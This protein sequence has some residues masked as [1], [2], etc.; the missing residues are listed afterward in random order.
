MG[1]H[2]R[3]LTRARMPHIPVLSP[4][5]SEA[6]DREAEAAGISRAVLMSAAGRAVAGVIAA[7]HSLAAE[8]GVLVAAGSGNNGGDGWVAARALHR[9]GVAVWVASL[10]S[11]RSP[12][13]ADAARLAL[14]DGVREVSPDGPWPTVG[15]V[16]DA[17]LGTGARG[18]PR[19]PVATLLER[20]ADLS[21]PII[22]VDGPTGL[23]LA[24]GVV[25]GAPAVTLSVTFGGVRRGHLLARDEAGDIVVAD[26]GHPASDPAW[27]ALMTDGA[28]AAQ[29]PR[30]RADFHKGDRGRIVIIGGAAG[31]AGAA[32][33]AARAA[34]ATG[35]GLVHVAAPA[36][37][38]ALLQAAEPDVQTLTHAFDGAPNGALTEL[39]DRAD[40]VVIGPGLGREPGRRDFVRQAIERSRRIVLDADG[41]IAFQGAAAALGPLAG[42]RQ[43]ILT[44]H[45]GEFRALWPELAATAEL[46]PWGAA[47]SAAALVGADA[48]VLL[49]G[50]PSVIATVGH[51]AMTVAAGNPGL[52]T[53]GS[54]DLLSGIIATLLAQGLDA[55]FAASIGAHALGRAAELAARRHTARAMRPVDVVQALPDL[56]REWDLVR[57]APR[58]P[59]PPMLLELAAPERV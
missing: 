46:D 37:T 48:T 22:A 49:K 40:A 14:A 55:H 10:R 2:P 33:M 5:Q 45:P 4:D 32:R 26:I 3:V 58:A 31:M 47:D 12:L 25:H 21:V 28:A 36:E 7:R 35:A 52:A 16:V 59:Q 18:A 11:G 57:R 24:T 9:S 17:L 1:R 34:F 43:L 27:P 30:F 15:L 13:C 54:G 53:G 44:P 8:R 20:L 19:P 42:G 23:D 29:L 51:G 50:V 6:W 39:L 56:W 38:T 41:L